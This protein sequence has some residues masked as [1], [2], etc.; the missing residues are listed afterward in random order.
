M[1]PRSGV[2]TVSVANPTNGYAAEKSISK[3]VSD[4]EWKP[5]Q[6][7]LSFNEFLSSRRYKNFICVSRE[8]LF[9][10]LLVSFFCKELFFAEKKKIR[11]LKK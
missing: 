4:G 8:K 1:Y 11:A 9:E 2:R 5:Y 6:K 10:R 3:V 7:F